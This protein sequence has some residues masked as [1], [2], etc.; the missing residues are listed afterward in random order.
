MWVA[1]NVFFTSLLYIFQ[2]TLFFGHFTFNRNNNHSL[3]TISVSFVDYQ[4]TRVKEHYLTS[5][6][7]SQ[8]FKHLE[9]Y[10]HCRAP[11]LQHIPFHVLDHALKSFQLKAELKSIF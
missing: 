4:S 2:Q 8:I 6:R 7:V 9:N 1:R 11:C 3:Y 10:E 5:D